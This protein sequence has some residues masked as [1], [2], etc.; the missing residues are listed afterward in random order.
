M[1]AGIGKRCRW[2]LEYAALC[3]V[4]VYVRLTPDRVWRATGRRFG[5]WI[6]DCVGYRRSVV[7]ENL[8]AAFPEISNTDLNKL[9][10][11]TY[12][13]LGETLCEFL[14][15][16]GWNSRTVAGRIEGLD[17]GEL[18]ALHAEGQGAILMTGHF[19]NWELLGAAV[20][21]AGLPIHVV[22]RSLS[23]P[24]TD[25]LQN[26]IRERSGLSVLK[27]DTSVREIV[28][29]VRRGEFVAMLP[30]VDAGEDGVFVDFMGRP[31]S[32]PRGVAYFAWKLRCPI[33]TKF[34]VA[35]ADRRYRTIDAEMFVPESGDDE[36]TAVKK[37]T[38]TMIANLEAAVRQQ[39]DHYLWLHRRWKTRP[40]P[41]SGGSQEGI[42]S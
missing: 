3:G 23:N 38:Q 24:W 30:D 12:R 7:R 36:S 19:G 35:G 8:A 32:T 25:R 14:A 20:A 41:N 17:L 42:D 40:S 16:S 9:S 29:A 22:A 34:L 21:A 5:Q 1:A 28:K 2:A 18:K 4:L 37:I 6:H 33:V 15:M 31:A 11:A 13:H 27:A 39:P 26:R 10:V